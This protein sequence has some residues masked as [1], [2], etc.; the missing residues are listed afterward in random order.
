MA[1]DI[2]LGKSSKWN[3]ESKLYSEMEPKGFYTGFWE[4]D[5]QIR[6]RSILKIFF[7][8]V[9]IA[10]FFSC[11]K[12]KI[13]EN[14]NDSEIYAVDITTETDAGLFLLHKDGSY[15]ILD[16]ENEIGSPVLYLNSSLKNPVNEGVSIVIDN[17]GFPKIIRY[18]DKVII[19]GNFKGTK[20]DA[21]LLDGDREPQYYWGL[22]TE[23]NFDLFLSDIPIKSMS[24]ET[25]A[26]L[27]LS[28]KSL[29]IVVAV[30]G[31][32]VAVTTVGAPLASFIGLTSL[33][34]YAWDMVT[35]QGSV[36]DL[37]GGSDAISTLDILDWDKLNV[38]SEMTLS[39]SGII[40]LVVAFGEYWAD[41]L[42]DEI[43]DEFKEAL[44]GTIMDD[45]RRPYQIQLSNY[46]LEMPFS[47]AKATIF[48]TTQSLWKIDKEDMGWCVA[49]KENDNLIDV[50][51]KEPYTKGGSRSATFLVYS[52]NGGVPCVYFTVEQIGIEYTISP[53]SLNF[54]V[55]GG[56]DGFTITVESP[57]TVET[58]ES[59]D[60][61]W[62]HVSKNGVSPVSVIVKVDPNEDKIRNTSVLVNFKLGEGSMST[63]VTV[64]QEGKDETGFFAGTKFDGTMWEVNIIETE[65]TSG[66]ERK[67][68][69]QSNG[70]YLFYDESFNNSDTKSYTQ[71]FKFEGDKYY[72]W[73][74]EEEND[75]E[76]W[77]YFSI[78]ND[79]VYFGVGEYNY[80][81]FLFKNGVSYE[82]ESGVETEML[83]I[84]RDNTFVINQET[85]NDC[86]FC[87][88]VEESRTA[89]FIDDN[90]D[91][92]FL[93]SGKSDFSGTI[94]ATETGIKSLTVTTTR[95]G[96][97]RM[98][99]SMPKSAVKM[100]NNTSNGFP[101]RMIGINNR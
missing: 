61:T 66:V 5:E 24:S 55:E 39:G 76:G 27:S 15:A 8:V 85:I 101:K 52:Q 69:V 73:S 59:L 75:Y 17:G 10:L 1:Q 89:Y 87:S 90:G 41:E 29:G 43:D 98:I 100:S 33:A 53:L 99:T 92:S 34:L 93:Y 42:Q 91:M 63:P 28:L 9:I 49:R 7:V 78:E 37:E 74:T 22:E 19:C 2:N 46:H 14:T 82:T 40:G 58:V 94:G 68:K 56:Q 57:A 18:K 54:K 36:V 16:Y 12:D 31:T 51:V 44:Y 4:P 60:S 11:S 6:K 35:P 48:V 50:E 70:K 77:L 88:D 79:S 62:C 47:P 81:E 21:V 32:A 65:K 3:Q 64:S 45:V 71:Y 67:R 84:E 30:A 96:I 83:S 86:E 26:W 95:N 97:G 72:T 25:K 13:E 80:K 38:K 23:L 20:F